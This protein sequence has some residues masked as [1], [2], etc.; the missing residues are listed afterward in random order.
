M[1]LN[2]PCQYPEHIL[3]FGFI[4]NTADR[5][6]IDRIMRLHAEGLTPYRISRETGI[7]IDRVKR[8][9]KVEGLRT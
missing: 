9:I 5:G 7:L 4:Q 6:E 1:T 2:Q 8:V 3:P